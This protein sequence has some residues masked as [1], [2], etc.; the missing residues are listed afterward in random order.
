MIEPNVIRGPE[1]LG[2]EEAAAR[3]SPSSGLVRL[4]H[5]R[6]ISMRWWLAIAFAVIAALTA[7]VV[8]G[9]FAQRS[10]MAIEHRS[11]DVAVARSFAAAAEIGR[12]AEL[13]SLVAQLPDIAVNREVTLFV[14]DAEGSLIGAEAADGGAPRRLPLHD[15]ALATALD[16]QRFLESSDGGGLVLVGLPFR[17]EGVGAV[18]AVS[19]ERDLPAALGLLRRQVFEAAGLAIVAGAL[20][21]LLIAILIGRRLRRVN[22]A[23]QAIEAGNFAERLEPGFRD[24]L[25]D[26]AYTVDR[27]RERLAGSFETLA[28]ER[29][30][31]DRILAR[32]ND[33]VVA[34]H[35]DLTIG[36][37]SENAR[38]ILGRPLEQGDDLPDPWEDFGLRSFAAGLFEP[39][40][41]GERVHVAD[42]DDAFDVGGIPALESGPAVLVVSDVSA[43][44]RR[45][46]AEREFVANAAHELRTPL[47]TILGAVEMLQSGAKEDEADRDMFLAHI[48][49][50]TQRLTRLVR[51]LLVLA[52]TQALQEAPATSDVELCSVLGEVAESLRPPDGVAVSVECA[53][54]LALRTHREL[55]EQALVNLAGNAA[56]H[57]S[58]GS[59]ALRAAATNGTATI[60]VADTGSGI[61]PE[62]A[63]RVFDRFY[64]G[65]SRSDDGFGL[66]L[67]IAAEAVRVLGGRLEVESEPNRGTTIRISLPLVEVEEA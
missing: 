32:L 52:R 1:R 67:A 18:I 48:E 2:P 16:G 53:E 5:D 3:K 36:F 61:S 60:E 12:A 46:R 57:T 37:A 8:A 55:L 50:E 66:G 42:G 11:E 58:T 9:L 29:D 33:G 39:G 22:A 62:H 65:Q 47:Q 17:Q 31:L 26:L 13:D 15:R 43:E 6:A 44:E 20:V 35:P 49:R 10:A 40:A 45:E 14:Y 27:M 25:G 24:E 54:G 51:A 4:L 23:A 38:R 30:R 34:V 41:R 56:K 21:G 28:S 19:E 64:R 59:I 63:E 7:L